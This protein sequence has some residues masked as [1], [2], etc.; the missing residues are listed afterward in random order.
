MI[1]LG[2][3]E[4]LPAEAESSVRIHVVPEPNPLSLLERVRAPLWIFD[5]GLGR[6]FWANAAGLEIWASHSLAELCARDMRADMSKAVAH[7][8]AQYQS[9]FERDEHCMFSELWTLYP[10][11][12]PRPLRVTFSGFRLEDGRMAMLCEAHADHQGS[13][14]NLRSAEALLH[15]SV[16]IVLYT[17]EGRALYLNPAA[18]AAASERYPLF[19][20]RFVEPG[21]Y[22]RMKCELDSCGEGRSVALVRTARGERWHEI[23]VRKS[24]DAVTGAVAWLASEMDVN[25]LK[26]AQHRENYLANH[27]L[28]T[29]LPNRNFVSRGFRDRIAELGR[30]N[31]RGALIF[32]DLD[33]FKN[34]NDSLGHAAGDELL[35]EMARRLRGV[36]GE[37]D[38]LARLGG[39]EFLVF[40]E[41]P[42]EDSRVDA[43]LPE[44]KP[45]LGN[46]RSHTAWLAERILAEVGRPV[47]VGESQIRV[48][49]TLG[50]AF[51]PDDGAD[52]ET[53]M[54]HADLAMYK[55]K[56]EGR[57]RVAYFTNAL[58]LAVKARLTLESE[59][60]LALERGEL[61]AFYQPR[62]DVATNAVRGAEALVRWNHPVRK[63]LYPGEFI[64]VAEETGLIS[65]LGAC[66]LEAVARAEVRFRSQGKQVALSANLSPRQFSDPE[67]LATVE[68]IVLRT[69]CDPRHIELEITESMLLGPGAETVRALEV[70]G[71]MGFRISIDDFGTGYS[72]LGY[73]QR[74]PIHGL[75][76]DR[77]FMHGLERATPIAALILTMCKM[78]GVETVA[79]GVETQAQLDWLREH[80]CDEYQGF[81][82]SPA[83]RIADFE[84]DF[85]PRATDTLAQRANLTK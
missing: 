85:L 13:P 61:E 59:L 44:T 75:K 58:N 62:L 46:A 12:E 51:F 40:T 7:R 83:V 17:H 84:S 26:N 15:T 66:V 53:L 10:G 6:V 28:L 30:A 25:D 42:L 77:S 41:A 9:E 76:I 16:M 5:I 64:G 47:P 55:A 2:E 35:V 8:L 36:L 79:E 80:G 43:M 37:S 81:L 74:Y 34:L 72:N 18:R 82:V 14:E 73:L 52:I 63:L 39:D 68:T 4:A 70:L 69:G 71:A 54:R 1:K 49:P 23:T 33:R 50:V 56:G 29:G 21:A 32:I 24:R 22:E 11:G 20:E 78:L 38:L 60:Q 31:T 57:N 45:T 48:T 67:F 19:C 65:A 27:D 3:G